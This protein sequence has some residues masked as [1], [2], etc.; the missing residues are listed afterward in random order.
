MEKLEKIIDP[1]VHKLHNDFRLYLTTEPSD[2]FPLGLLQMCLKVTN[3]PP[4]G[5]KAGMLRSFSSVIS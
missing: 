1:K 4:R 3:E 5:L 2:K